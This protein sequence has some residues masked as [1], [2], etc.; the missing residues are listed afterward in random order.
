MKKK[1]QVNNTFIIVFS[2]AIVVLILISVGSYIFLKSDKGAGEVEEDELVGEEIEPSV[3]EKIEIT[4]IKDS[5]KPR[6]RMGGGSV[7]GGG[8]GGGAPSPTPTPEPSEELEDDEKEE[9]EEI[10]AVP[11][12]TNEDCSDGLYCNGEEICNEG[13]CQPGIL[14]EYDDGISCTIDNCDEINDIV[15]HTADNE[16]CQDG[17]YCNGAE[18]CDPVNDCQAG[19][20][21]DVDDGILCTVDSC[22]EGED[23]SDDLGQVVYDTNEC[24]CEPETQEVDC[25]DN[26]ACTDD[27]CVDFACSNNNNN[28]NICDDEFWCTIGDR[29]YEGSCISDSKPVDDGVSCT[30]DSC[31]EVN[32]AIVH[33]PDDSLCDDGLYCNGF[34]SCDVI[35]DC[36]LGVAPSIDDGV[37]CTI[38]NCDEGS[39]TI[40]NTP[41]NNLCEN[42]LYCDGAE[43]CDVINDCQLGVAPSIDDGVRC[44]IDNCDEGTDTITNSPDDSLCED[45]GCKVGMCSLESG[46]SFEV[47]SSCIMPESKIVNNGDSVQGPLVMKLQRKENGNWIT[48]ETITE[49]I[50]VPANGIV[51]LSEYWNDISASSSGIH[52]VYASFEFNGQI[53][54]DDWKIKVQDGELA[55]KG[56][57]E[58]I[59]SWFK[60]LFGG[61][62]EVEIENVGELGTAGIGSG[63][64]VEILV[65]TVKDDYDTGEIIELTTAETDLDSTPPPSGC[66]YP[67]P[68][69]FVPVAGLNKPNYLGFVTEPVFCSKITRISKN[70][71]ERI[72]NQDGEDIGRWGETT[73]NIY[74]THTNW[75]INNEL[76]YLRSYKPGFRMTFYADS[77]LPR[78]KEAVKNS[79]FRWSKNPSTPYVQYAFPKDNFYYKWD[80]VNG[81]DRNTMEGIETI[82]LPFKTL[83]IPKLE[84]AYNNGKEYMAM[85]GTQDDTGDI[86]VYVI[87]LNNVN[88]PGRVVASYKLENPTSIYTHSFRFSPDGKHIL[89]GYSPNTLWRILDVDLDNGQITLHRLPSNPSDCSS[90]CTSTNLDNGYFPFVWGHPVFGY[91]S[92]RDIYLVGQNSRWNKKVLQGVEGIKDDNKLGMM[93]AYNTRTKQYKSLTYPDMT[94]PGPG[95]VSGESEPFHSSAEGGYAFVS[96]AKY[97]PGGR[98]GTKYEKELLA[99]DITNPAGGIYRLGHHRANERNGIR[100]QVFPV[101]SPD[102]KK[103]FFSSSWGD[104]QSQVEGYI[105]DLDLP[106]IL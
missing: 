106:E 49:N 88:N 15:T 13:D 100:Y 24:T 51:G 69:I 37:G 6:V 92:D 28:A 14:S 91:G 20:A 44:T 1:S 45:Y 17:L 54:E 96:Y 12:S 103:L 53:I 22:D 63:N 87:E 2:I 16:L 57:F 75:N 39:D 29:C 5:L 90:S 27:V 95:A 72:I 81:Y 85:P 102:L 3:E 46:C 84:I 79:D 70:Y 23:V 77:L 47:D 104:D 25:N 71:D 10:E 68:D 34:E 73:K 97:T 11:C 33:N 58:I 82:N 9:R 35:N 64:N 43:V 55:T 19:T 18:I 36:Q 61:K 7:G 80:V 30:T 52:R 93:T 66:E 83:K 65:A 105:I 86:Y 60:N 78:K 56:F 62:E 59:I 38:D 74:V 42:G 31:D 67:D 48:E 21:V 89:Y 98:R 4:L 76:F 50:I 99:I 8:G 26:N 101:A 40:I 94:N 41:S 32:D